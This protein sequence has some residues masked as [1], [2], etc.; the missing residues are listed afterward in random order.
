M[1]RLTTTILAAAA[2]VAMAGCSEKPRYI[3]PPP[4]GP[5]GPINQDNV[6]PG[7]RADFERSVISNTINFALDRYDI[8]AHARAILDSQAA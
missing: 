4:G 1:A 6:A 2:L 7:S 8:D 3:P 5:S